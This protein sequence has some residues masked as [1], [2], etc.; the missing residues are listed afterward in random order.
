MTYDLTLLK[1]NAEK[2]ESLK[3]ILYQAIRPKT[4][5]LYKRS[6]NLCSTEEEICFMLEK[7]INEKMVENLFH[8]KNLRKNIDGICY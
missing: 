7:D 1:W 5:L 3:Q 6:K 4:F 8:P 2:R